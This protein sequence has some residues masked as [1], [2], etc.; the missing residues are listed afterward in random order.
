MRFG[1]LLCDSC[2]NFLRMII[3]CSPQALSCWFPVLTL[4]IDVTV[5]CF[6]VLILDNLALEMHSRSIADLQYV[7]FGILVYIGDEVSSMFRSFCYVCRKT[8]I[9]TY[10]RKSHVLLCKSMAQF[11]DYYFLRWTYNRLVIGF[12][13]SRWYWVSLGWFS[14][15][16]CTGLRMVTSQLVS[17]LI[18]T[19]QQIWA[20]QF[21]W[22]G[23]AMK[24]WYG[25]R[26]C[27]REHKW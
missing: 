2:S 27:I 1:S 23:S 13:T 4:H 26:E 19:G 10:E 16:I 8:L 22:D 14:G 18:W 5:C 17:W 7:Q 6:W 20:H 3:V 11:I 12:F 15:E 9:T 25:Q 21:N 24:S